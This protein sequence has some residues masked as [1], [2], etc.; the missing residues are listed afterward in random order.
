MEFAIHDVGHG[1][2]VS[3]RHRNGNTMLWDCGHKEGARP[4]SFLPRNGWAGVTRFFVTNYDEDHL[5]DLPSLRA[6]LMPRELARNKSV[7]G[8]QLEALKARGGAIS[9]AMASMIDMIHSYTAG[10]ITPPPP[11]P[12]VQCS[13]YNNELGDFYETNDLSLVTFLHVG[14]V[15]A[16]IPGDIQRAGWLK[17]LERESFRDELARVQIFLASHHGRESGYCEEVFAY[18]TNVAVVVFSD[19]E[20]QYATQEMTATYASHAS[21]IMWDGRFRRVLTTR[22]DGDLWFRV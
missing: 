20:K 15:H 21:G 19:S 8:S 9:P 4:S 5:S 17:L 12:G 18:A 10:P 3:F 16:I 22:S 2:C 14:N 13:I 1:S 11:F 6:V 7:T